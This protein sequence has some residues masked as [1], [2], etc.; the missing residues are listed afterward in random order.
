MG[1]TGLMDKIVDFC[2]LFVGRLRGGIA[3]VTILA[4]MMFGCISGSASPASLHS[5]PS[6]CP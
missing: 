3:Y 6:R 5:A 4:N 1:K 2:R